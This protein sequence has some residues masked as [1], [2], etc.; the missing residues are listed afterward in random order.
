MPFSR[1]EDVTQG[2]VRDSSIYRHISLNHKDSER[3][4]ERE[5]ER[6]RENP[7]ACV[8]MNGGDGALV[9]D[10]GHASVRVLL[11]V[12]C[13]ARVLLTLLRDF[14]VLG[15]AALYSIDGRL[16]SANEDVSAYTR[17]RRVPKSDESC[18]VQRSLS[19]Q[20]FFHGMSA[21]CL[22]DGV[23]VL[24]GVAMHGGDDEQQPIVETRGTCVYRVRLGDD[25]QLVVKCA[26]PRAPCQRHLDLQNE[27]RALHRVGTSRLVVEMFGVASLP[28]GAAGAVLRFAPGGS[29]QRALRAPETHIT[30]GIALRWFYR[31]VCA[32]HFLHG[33][34]FL[35]GDV[36]PSNFLF[37]HDG[38][39]RLCDL[40][41]A[42]RLDKVTSQRLA[43]TQY[44]APETLLNTVNLTG[45]CDVYALAIT[46]WEMLHR[47]HDGRYQ[48]PY[49]EYMFTFYPEE[50]VACVARRNLR[51]SIPAAVPLWLRTLVC[52]MWQ[53]APQERPTCAKILHIVR[54][55]FIS[56]HHQ[57]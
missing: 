35:H 49:A 30:P 46:L 42:Q 18:T 20:R 4:S 53:G 17:L 48:A 13:N 56:E 7:R 15:V 57:R 36:K 3:A 25:D 33:R 11:G 23:R 37:D 10:C 24:R 19:F 1:R 14:G 54:C 44:C 9:V 8:T 45:A 40:G 26:A 5:S 12:R 50:L 16:L 31:C 2:G 52:L 21:L 34:G 51:P 32:V 43:T 47:A 27:V 38:S 39:L 55:V 28:N 22:D 6:E 29:L 41:M